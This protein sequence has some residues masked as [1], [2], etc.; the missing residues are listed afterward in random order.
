MQFRV[1]LKYV[2]DKQGRLL[3]DL[4]YEPTGGTIYFQ[5]ISIINLYMFRAGLLL[6]IRRYYSVY[7]VIGICHAFM[8]TGCWQD[9]STSILPTGSKP[10]RNTQRLIA[11]IN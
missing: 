6:I 4:Q 5:F 10:P 1:C 9:R 8:L 11:E 3:F 2:I 7:T